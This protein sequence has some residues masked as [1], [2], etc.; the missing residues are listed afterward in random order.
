MEYEMK[1]LLPL[2]I[3]LT[4]KYTSKESSSVPYE[5]A[6]MLMEAVI[7]CVNENF[8]NNED[9]MMNTG[10]MIN[11]EIMYERGYHIMIE[12]V[13]K[14]KEIYENIIEDFEDYGCKNYKDTLIKGI[15]VFFLRYNAKF[16]PQNHILTLDYPLITGNPS[17]CGI[18][19]ILEYLKGIQIEKCFLDCFD[20]QEVTDLLEKVMPEYQSLYLDNL[21]YQVLLSAIGCMIAEKPVKNLKLSNTDYDEIKFYFQG[22]SIDK[23]EDKIISII[24][25]LMKQFPNHVSYFEKTAKN[26]AVR[27]WNGIQNEVLENVIIG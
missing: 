13:Y 2:V 12:K 16:N 4:E 8:E 7:Y 23:M 25:I 3:K 15:P 20:R 18:D 24:R 27:I 10:K 14:A 26:Y 19:L 6:R 21:C 1:E 5:T 17:L 9:S 11:A 22:D